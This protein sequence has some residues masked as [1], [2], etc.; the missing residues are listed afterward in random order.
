M[1]ETD[2]SFIIDEDLPEEPTGVMLADVGGIK[3]K[4]KGWHKYIVIAVVILLVAWFTSIV[5][6]SPYEVEESANGKLVKF[7]KYHFAINMPESWEIDRGRDKFEAILYP[8]K[9]T[10]SREA[11][12]ED[13][14]IR[15]RWSKEEGSALKVF[16]K[17]YE[18]TEALGASIIDRTTN[19]GKTKMS[20]ATEPP[21]SKV[22]AFVEHSTPLLFTTAEPNDTFNDVLDSFIVLEK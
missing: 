2:S 14:W 13:E 19:G 18:D 16:E 17:E 7:E 6:S 9:Y 21:E 15:V 11:I 3:K 1:S 12:R 5:G 8:G 4:P 22:S 10:K 20:V